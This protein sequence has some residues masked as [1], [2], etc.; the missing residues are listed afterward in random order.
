MSDTAVV[1]KTR[2]KFVPVPPEAIIKCWQNTA[3]DGQTSQDLHERLRKH[4]GDGISDNVESLKTVAKQYVK[5]VFEGK[6]PIVDTDGVVRVKPGTIIPLPKMADAERI[7]GVGR[8]KYAL[9]M[10][11]LSEFDN[12]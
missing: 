5:E 1:K 11:K 3:R 12:L 6:R 4:F 7:G 9:D 10:S 8:E 2:R